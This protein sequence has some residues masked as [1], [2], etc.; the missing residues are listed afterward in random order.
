[1]FLQLTEDMQIVILKKTRNVYI[2][3]YP[4]SLLVPENPQ[5][6]YTMTN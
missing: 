3:R 6:E 2:S 4:P 5:S 1:M